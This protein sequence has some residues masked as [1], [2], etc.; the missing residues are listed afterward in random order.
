[1][2]RL[3]VQYGISGNGLAKI[4]DR[5]N[6]PYPPRGYWA[7]KEAGKPVVTFQLPPAEAGTL[8]SETI[9]PTPPPIELAPEI[10]ERV[11]AARNAVASAVVSERLVRPHPIIAKWLADFEIKKRQAKQERDPWRKSI[12]DPGQLSDADHRRRRILDALFKALDK[13]GAKADED[14]RRQ[15]SITIQ[16]EKIEFQLREKLKQVRAPLT[17]REK[18]WGIHTDRGWRQE[19]QPIGKFLFAIK[20]YLPQSLRR[21]WLETDKAPLETLLPDIVAT[22]VAAAP[23]LVEQRKQQEEAENQRRI[24]EQQRYEAKQRRKLDDNRW[25]RFVEFAELRRETEMAR[26]FLE[27]LKSSGIESEEKKRDRCAGD[28]IRWAEQRLVDVDPLARGVKG[29]FENVSHVCAWDY[30]D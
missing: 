2:S 4:C 29:I 16:N 21:E 26:A 14:E 30:R 3:A 13:Q 18:Q 24:A 23:L 9:A 28:W 8:A 17:D 1:M 5:L 27:E 7:K 11:D 25:R 20:T 10:K 22:F 19:L 6:V 12:I 15:L